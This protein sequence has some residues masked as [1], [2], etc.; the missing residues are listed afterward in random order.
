MRL[1]PI[2]LDTL[3]NPEHVSHIQVNVA[4]GP[5]NGEHFAHP[6]PVYSITMIDGTIYYVEAKNDYINTADNNQFVPI[7]WLLTQLTQ[8]H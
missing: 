8:G 5:L 7:T 3:I 4:T 6:Y 2:M 1:V